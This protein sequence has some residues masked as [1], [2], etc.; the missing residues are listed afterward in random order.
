MA[1][2]T[3]GQNQLLRCKS[4]SASWEI[5]HPL[6][7]LKV[8]YHVHKNPLLVPILNQ[9]CPAI[10]CCIGHSKQ[11]VHV[12]GALCT[13]SLL[14][15]P[16]DEEPPFNGCPRQLIQNICNYP[17]YLEAVFSVCNPRTCHA[18]VKGI[19]IPWLLRTEVSNTLLL[20]VCHALVEGT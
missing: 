1:T 5:P 19:H 13:V 14:P 18:M 4:H 12:W 15:N 9:M 20:S 3:T 16:Q 7:N 6:W 10:Y 11:S 2:N 8:H 17:P